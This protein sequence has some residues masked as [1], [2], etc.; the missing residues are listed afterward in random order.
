MSLHGEQEIPSTL[1]VDPSLY[2]RSLKVVG[3]SSKQPGLDGSVSFDILV[4]S[5]R[6]AMGALF[7]MIGP[8]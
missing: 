8:T 1:V 2:D 4:S 5:P 6:G 7:F 3:M